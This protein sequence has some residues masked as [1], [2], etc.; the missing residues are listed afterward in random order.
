[1]N[2]TWSTPEYMTFNEIVFTRVIVE[3]LIAATPRPSSEAVTQFFDNLA[4][5]LSMASTALVELD[6][7]RILE[8]NH[9]EVVDL[10]AEALYMTSVVFLA[11]TRTSIQ[12]ALLAYVGA[13][14]VLL[15]EYSETESD[16]L[17]LVEI[18]SMLSV[19]GDSRVE[20]EFDTRLEVVSRALSLYELRRREVVAEDPEAAQDAMLPVKEVDIDVVMG[21]VDGQADAADLDLE[22]LAEFIMW[23][24][25]GWIRMMPSA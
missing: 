7:Q 12:E 14:S 6:Q 18:D 16:E 24:L 2:V 4:L 5:H 10:F 3:E 22:L 21:F 25:S 17:A 23:T 15:K 19:S 11:C 8:V 13:S 9:E 1:M 20:Y